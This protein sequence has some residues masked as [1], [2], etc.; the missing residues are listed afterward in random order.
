MDKQAIIICLMKDIWPSIAAHGWNWAAMESF[1]QNTNMEIGHIKLAFPG[2]MGEILIALNDELD[3]QVAAKTQ[4]GLGITTTLKTTIE[5]KI[6]FK[7]A[8]KGAFKKIAQSLLTPPHPFLSLKLAFKTVNR[9]WYLAGDQSTD[10]NY[11]SKRLLLLYVYVPTTLYLL[12]KDKTK[13]D[14]II[15]MNRR[16]TEVALIPKIKNRIKNFI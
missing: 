2:G 6:D 4:K 5:H 1:C 11:Y 8:H 13:E 10:Y 3:R 7:L 9:F 14:T 12:T 15:F 16:F